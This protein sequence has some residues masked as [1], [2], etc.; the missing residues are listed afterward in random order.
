M[1]SFQINEL[2]TKKRNL[3]V[4]MDDAFRNCGC[5]VCSRNCRE[6]YMDDNDE[7]YFQILIMIVETIRMN[8]HIC[9]ANE[10]VLRVG[11]DVL[12]SQI[13]DAF[14]NGCSAMERMIVE[15]IGGLNK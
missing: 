3:L 14:R 10:I 12:A 11:R 5:V 7:C 4:K 13:I 6:K 15:I 2:V 8:Q 1:R 9:V